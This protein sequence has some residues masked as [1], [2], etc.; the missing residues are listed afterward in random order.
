LE[1][2]DAA[3]TKALL[4]EVGRVLD[5]QLKFL[6]ELS[7]LREEVLGTRRTPRQLNVLREQ[8]MCSIADVAFEL[9][10]FQ[11]AYKN[12]K[13]ALFLLEAHDHEHR[14]KIYSRLGSLL[15]ARGQTNAALENYAAALSHD[16]GHLPTLEGLVEIY[17]TLG[18]WKQVA[19][20]KR[21]V[22]DNTE[23]ARDRVRTLSELVDIWTTKAQN[24]QKAL[25]AL[26]EALELEPHNRE[27]LARQLELYQSLEVWH[28][29][30]D[31]LRAIAALESDPEL[32][33]MYVFTEGQIY[34][35][36]IE[37]PLH[38][39]ELFCQALKLNPNYF[40]AME[41]IDR[42]RSKAPT[43]AVERSRTGTH[44][45]YQPEASQLRGVRG[46]SRG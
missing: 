8:T 40:E 30:T 2:A 36:K 19:A 17:S 12:Y 46:A 4:I 21:Q 45:K 15:F 44:K 20:F 5:E 1:A 16:P 10:D 31:T 34:L 25:E 14:T 23:L 42:C 28:K 29:A 38:A 22:L 24:P 37:D 39:S 7:K 33:A 32:K 27:L 43:I 35:D 13:S 26:E 11:K 9:R 6:A 3:A 41:R 18:D